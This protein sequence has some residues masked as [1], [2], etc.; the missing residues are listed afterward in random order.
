M[1]QKVHYTCKMDF[2][3]DNVENKKYIFTLIGKRIKQA[4]KAKGYTQERLAEKVDMT[5]KNL[6]A[7]ENGATG[8][9]I[10]SL[11]AICDA[12]EVS[13]DYILFGDDAKQKQ[14][15]AS[16]LLAKLPEQKRIQAEKL[17]E[18]FVEAYTD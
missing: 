13:S 7:L 1:L 10:S 18:V 2:G 17:L 6:S 9:S 5:T 16:I 12:L 11:I 14:D 4:R 8:M 15:T 3:S